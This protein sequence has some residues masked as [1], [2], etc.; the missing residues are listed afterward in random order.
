MPVYVDSC[1]ILDIMTDDEL[2]GEW[3][4]KTLSAYFAE[5]LY[6]NGMVYAEICAGLDHPSEA[7][8][9]LDELG[10]E[11]KVSSRHGLWLAAK[12]FVRYRA[13]GGVKTS[14]LPDFL[15]G[16]QAEAEKLPLITRDRKRFQTYFPNVKLI[17]PSQSTLN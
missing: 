10:L 15:I 2:H 17:S 14:P 9:I 7:D 3:S 12:A 11:L 6:V 4:A 16:A 13:A 5:G 1:V 8:Q